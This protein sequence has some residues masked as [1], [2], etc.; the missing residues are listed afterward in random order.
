MV[1]IFNLDIN[2]ERVSLIGPVAT[3]ASKSEPG[4]FRTVYAGKCDCPGAR[5]RGKCRHQDV[6]KQL[7]AAVTGTEQAERAKRI[8]AANQD[9]W[10]D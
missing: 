3:V 5:F 10:G 4:T 8:Q 7:Q 2:G 9:I 1:P 6:V